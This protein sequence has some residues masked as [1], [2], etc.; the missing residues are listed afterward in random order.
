MKKTMAYKHKGMKAPKADMKAPK[1]DQSAAPKVKPGMQHKEPAGPYSRPKGGC[2][3]GEQSKAPSH[4]KAALPTQDAPKGVSTPN[5]GA[6]VSM[7]KGGGVG[8]TEV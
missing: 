2:H 7:P 6:S 3:D 4:K 1:L 8:E 5:G